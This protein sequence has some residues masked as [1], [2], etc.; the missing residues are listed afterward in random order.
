MT[1]HA[2]DEGTEDVPNEDVLEDDL[3]G[4]EL[5]DHDRQPES[6]GR[7]VLTEDRQLLLDNAE[8]LAA[9]RGL[10]VMLLVGEV[11]SGKT[12]LLVAIWNLFLAQGSVGDI[13]FAGSR[14]ALGFERRAWRS[15]LASREERASTRRTYQEDNGFL[16]LRIS[17]PE[18]LRE[19]LFSDV[20]GE[21]FERIRQGEP[22]GGY[23]TWLSRVDAAVVLVSGRALAD[24]ALRSTALSNTRSLLRQMLK[25]SE[26]GAMRVAV[27][28]TMGDLVV[29][30]TRR[31]WKKEAQPLLALAREIDDDAAIIETAARPEDGGSPQ[32][33]DEL[34]AWLLRAPAPAAP[35]PIAPARTA[36]IAGRAR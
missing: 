4:E 34:L 2:P 30:N 29:N 21:T 14:T 12:T 27:V 32:G 7:L 22:L 31:Q 1:E 18:G 36:R 9:R 35:V 24:N 25:A 17:T 23:I 13:S 11:E 20:A 28:L 6:E 10:D 19:L 5:D 33:L 8:D 3:P 26:R 16:H 15:R